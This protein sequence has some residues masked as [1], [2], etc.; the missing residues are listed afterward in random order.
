MIKIHPDG[1]ITFIWSDHLAPLRS[2]G[3]TTIRRASTVEPN[4][5]GRWEA[6]LSLS[7]GPVLGPFSH[8]RDAIAAEI[9]WLRANGY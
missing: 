4:E 8:R 2:I 1:R 7:G 3:Q 5:D 6:D 9:E